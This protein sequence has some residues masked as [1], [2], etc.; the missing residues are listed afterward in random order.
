MAEL[1]EADDLFGFV[2][3]PTIAKKPQQRANNQFRPF[4]LRANF[5]DKVAGS[6]YVELGETCVLC[7]IEGPNEKD[8]ETDEDV[9]DDSNII[10]EDLTDEY[11]TALDQIVDTFVRTELLLNAEVKIYIKVISNDGGVLAACTM[12]MGLALASA[13]IQ[14]FDLPLA[15]TVL[16]EKAGTGKFVLDPTTSQCE[17]AK[18]NDGGWITVVSLPAFS[19]IGHI[20]SEGVMTVK[21][22]KWASEL[23]FKGSLS[24]YTEVS[25]TL[26]ES[27]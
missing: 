19:Q 13:N 10:S 23:A 1:Q 20:L 18:K 14:M 9:P 16:V 5:L 17:S 2:S 6:G 22:A 12:A 26:R 27:L 3:I 4:A 24:L 25:N 11:F 21:E 15:A 8:R 7:S